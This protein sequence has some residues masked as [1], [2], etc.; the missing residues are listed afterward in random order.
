[1]ELPS[2]EICYRALEGRDERFDGFLFIGVTSTGV[3][4]RPVCRV[5]TPRFQNCRF[6]RTA[7]SAQGSGFR[8]CLRCRPETAPERPYGRELSFSVVRAMN[9]ITDGTLD[10]ESWSMDE[11]SK[12]VGVGQRQLRRLFLR[13]FGAAPNAVAQTRRILL[14]KQLIHETQMPLTDVALAAGFGSIR[15][16]NEVFQHLFHCAPGTLRRQVPYIQSYEGT[17]TTLRLRYRPPYDW[18]AMLAYLRSHAIQ[19]LEIIDDYSYHRTIEFSGIVGSIRVFHVPEEQSL[20][21]SMRFPDVRLIPTIVSRVRSMFDV[22]AEI[23]VIDAHLSQDPLLRR[24]VTAHP[25]LRVPGAWHGFELTVRAILG[26]QVSIAAAAK[27]GSRLV[28]LHGR[29]VPA[30]L[31][32]HPALKHAF[33]MAD[34]FLGRK[35]T[36]VGM[37]SVREQALR[38]V[39]GLVREDPELFRPVD[40]ADSAIAKLRSVAGVG[41]WT[42]QYVALR[43]FQ[44]VDA[45]PAGDMVLLKSIAELEGKPTNR[46][47]L[48]HRSESWRPW[49]A[50][51]AQHL[52]T[53]YGDRG[54]C[55]MTAC[56]NVS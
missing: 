22:G 21:V 39:A 41:D 3:Y 17:D 14:A 34:R 12:R 7:A 29:S 37:P 51:A 36:G 38:S 32:I 28:A 55:R 56:F 8:P 10:T 1:M 53:W 47:Q 49:R 5:R 40:S 52:W 45:L 15:R 26:Q 30:E 24:L 50:Y 54:R 6:F 20:G 18:V 33:P 46:A 35:S 31:A 48:L 25:G 42:A 11:L 16:F 4:C 43:A 19:G 2:P 13:H 27:L 23:D 9:Y 44:Q